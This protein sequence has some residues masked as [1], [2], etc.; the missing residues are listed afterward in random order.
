MVPTHPRDLRRRPRPSIGVGD[1]RVKRSPTLGLV[2]GFLGNFRRGLGSI[3]RLPAQPKRPAQPAQPAPY[4]PPAAPFTPELAAP[5]TDYTELKLVEIPAYEAPEAPAYEA[6]EAPTF[7]AP[8]APTYEASAAPAPVYE[9][10]PEAPTPTYFKP[11]PE[12]PAP[13]E[14]SA[15]GSPHLTQKPEQPRFL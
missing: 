12:D 6:P 9:P 11:S 14:A 8:E 1:V 3:F 15:L 7:E 10:E 5:E 4:A 2:G 13:Y